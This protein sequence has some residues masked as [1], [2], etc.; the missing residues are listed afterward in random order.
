[1]GEGTQV[2]GSLLGYFKTSLI[3]FALSGVFAIFAAMI[4]QLRLTLF[5]EGVEQ[6]ALYGFV[7]LALF[8]AIHYVAP[9]FTGVENDKFICASGGAITLGVILY[10][11][12]FIVGG[13]VQQKKLIDGGV[14]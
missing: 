2:K 12:T 6:L 10:A 1:M 8:G 5:G 11:A 14:P 13:I 9:R 3:F 4:P 7:G